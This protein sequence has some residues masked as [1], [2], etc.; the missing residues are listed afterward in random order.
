MH[1]D[2]DG[3]R[4]RLIAQKQEHL[5]QFWNVLHDEQ[6]RELGQALKNLDLDNVQQMYRQTS[7]Q[8]TQNAVQEAIDKLMQPV[9]ESSYGGVQRN[10]PEEITQFE[11]IGLE[12]ISRDEVAV[13]LL[14]G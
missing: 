1:V 13:I 12:A 7:D 8:S 6:Q 3:L 2:L 11:R 10:S 4:E 14:A 9:P 5:L